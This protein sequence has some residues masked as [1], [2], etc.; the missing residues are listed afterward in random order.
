MAAVPPKD[1]EGALSAEFRNDLSTARGS[2]EQKDAVGNTAPA[3]QRLPKDDSSTLQ[4]R[5]YRSLQ[6]SAVR[7][8]LSKMTNLE[9]E[10]AKGSLVVSLP[11]AA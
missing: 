4:G 2:D 11:Y 6:S 10:E 5:Q 7:L 1:A 8:R 3:E 9:S